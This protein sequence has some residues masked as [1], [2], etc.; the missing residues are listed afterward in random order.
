MLITC[1][2]H[3]TEVAS[4]HT[5]VEFAYRLLTEDK[6]QFRAILENT[7]FMLVPSLNPDGVDIVTRVVS[8]DARHAVRRDRRRRELYHKYVG[9][10]NNRD[11]YIFSQAE[12]QL[13]ISQAAQRLASA[14]R[15]RRPPAGRQR[16]AHV[17]AAVA[18]S[19]RAEH[20]CRSWRRI[21]NMIGTSHGRRSDR[22]RARPGVAINS[23]YDFW[24][25][26]RHYQALSRR[27]A[28]PDGIGERAAGIADHR[29]AG[30]DR[31]RT[32]LGY[33]AR[34]R[35]WN[36]LE[37]WLG[38][39]WRLRDII[40]YQLIALE[41]CLYHAAITA[42][43]P[44]AE[45][46]SDRTAAGRAD[47]A[48]RVRYSRRAA[49][50]RR[51]AQDARDAAVRRGGDR[52][53]GGAFHGRRA[54]YAQVATSSACSSPTASFAK[55]LLERQNY[56]DLRLYPGGPPK[57]PYDVTA[58]TLPLLMGVETQA[59]ESE[60]SAKLTPARGYRFRL[61]HR[62]AST[63]WAASDVYSWKN[64]N[65]ELAV[66]NPVFRD[67]SGDWYPA[68]GIGRTAVKRPRIGLYRS[69]MPAMDEG[70]TR[71]VLEE[72]EFAYTSLT[73]GDV[74]RG[75]LRE[76]FDTIVF[77]DQS[78]S[79]ILEGYREGTMPPEYTGGIGGPGIAA[80]GILRMPGARSC[81]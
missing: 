33:N 14:D 54:E 7:I 34:E 81:S 59:I 73:N 49:R 38:G 4:T 2:I 10:D 57:R 41:S 26:A 11:W 68:P 67:A 64:V 20:R 70:W 16:I 13:T 42:R 63:A 1:S 15:L 50:P 77:P 28:H 35:S 48:V 27:P 6:P 18:R 71:W 31:R 24:T 25:P 44:A 79:S 66:G 46:L 21:R 65:S 9:H 61:D 12:T 47:V 62:P 8:Q 5:A 51:D 74:Q 56:P 45:L 19:D 23:L 52:T 43:R 22:G 58:H 3:A 80:L 29:Q 78:V 76:R 40:D 17:R 69:W 72:F 75:S 36:Y 60:F 53:G 32:A 30:R 55:T 39:T 37:P